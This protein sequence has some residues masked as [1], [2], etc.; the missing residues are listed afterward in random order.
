MTQKEAYEEIC[1]IGKDHALIWQAYGGIVTIVDVDVQ[2]QEGIYEHIQF[3][4]GL[5][6]FP[7]NETIKFKDK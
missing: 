2:K 3:T 6:D 1:R 5:G 7:K 4:H